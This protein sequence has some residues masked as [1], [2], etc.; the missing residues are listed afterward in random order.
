MRISVRPITDNGTCRDHRCGHPEDLKRYA[1]SFSR[2]LSALKA[3]PCLA[4]KKLTRC[5]SQDLPSKFVHPNGISSMV[6][7]GYGNAIQPTGATRDL[8]KSAVTAQ[9]SQVHNASHPLAMAQVSKGAIPFAPDPGGLGSSSAA[10]QQHKTPARPPQNAA[11]NKSAA[12]SS[13]RYQNGELIELP[14]IQ[15]DDE[16]EDDEDGDGDSH[17]RGQNQNAGGKLVAP[18]ADSP[19][20]RSALVQQE[21]MDPGQIFGPPV[22]LVMEEV[23]NVRKDR[24]RKFRARTSSANWSGV[25]RLTEDDIRKDMAARDK[26]RREGGW[27]YELSRDMA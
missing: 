9:H 18:W 17:Q 11:V 5:C 25:D 16:D 19:A 23:F 2:I 1:V 26:L 21:T 6:P 24:W 20:L 12:K 27:T 13:P 3:I 4:V 10:V 14:E 8:F 7:S 22:P 15:T